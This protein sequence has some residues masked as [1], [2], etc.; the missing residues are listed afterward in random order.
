MKSPRDRPTIAIAPLTTTRLPLVVLLACQLLYICCLRTFRS[1]GDLKLD[2][3]SFLQRA[4]AVT[5]DCGIMDE[6]IGT[7][8]APD[9][10]ISFRIIKPFYVT[11]QRVLLPGIIRAL[12]GGCTTRSGNIQTLGISTFPRAGFRDMSRESYKTLHAKWPRADWQG[13]WS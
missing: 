3:I 11:D 13:G 12:C 2:R 10:A 9:K 5:S 6:N 8:V 1:R 7:I 4:V